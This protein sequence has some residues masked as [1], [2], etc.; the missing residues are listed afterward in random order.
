MRTTLTLD[1]DIAVLLHRFQQANDLTFKQA[2]NQAL[3]VGL[4][5]E[6]S[7][8]KRPKRSYTH[9]VDAGKCLVGS[10]ENIH[11]VLSIVEGELRR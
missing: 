8:K 2:V 4:E 11:E 7:P 6:P 3:R 10:L 1:D 9:P 5:Q